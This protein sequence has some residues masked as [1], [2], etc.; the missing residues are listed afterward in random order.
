MGRISFLPL[1]NIRF[2]VPALAVK[3]RITA[4]LQTLRFQPEVGLAKALP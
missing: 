1:L 3:D 2:V 4:E